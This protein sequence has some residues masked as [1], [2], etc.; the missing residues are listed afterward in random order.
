MFDFDNQHYYNRARWYNPYNG[1]F[2][3]TDPFAGNSRDPQSL[4]KYLYC[5]ANPINGIDPSGM[6][7]FSLSGVVTVT[8]I[9][10]GIVGLVAGAV[11]GSQKAGKFFSWETFKWAIVG[12][13]LGALTGAIIGAAGWT[14]AHGGFAA[15]WKVVS[16]GFKFLTTKLVGLHSRS[17]MLGI[18]GFATGFLHGIWNPN[19]SYTAI[20]IAVAA[21]TFV[22]NML[23]TGLVRCKV[24][25]GPAAV[26]VIVFLHH[27]L[28]ATAFMATYF[29]AGYTVGFTT[30]AIVR[31]SYDAIFGQ[32]GSLDKVKIDS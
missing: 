11:L 30:G 9:I 18:F 26:S 29:A 24:L 19:F 12:L 13:C 25:F 23:T 8:A 2:N 27:Y 15:L 1:R 17:L 5:H 20:G 21:E 7:S 28:G 32:S 16:S 14:V 31:R 4:H 3:R 6:M 10:G 22:L